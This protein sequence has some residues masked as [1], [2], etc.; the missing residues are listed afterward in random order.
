[1]QQGF[2]KFQLFFQYYLE[3]HDFI[4]QVKESPLSRLQK[5]AIKDYNKIYK[6]K[7]RPIKYI[8]IFFGF[9]PNFKSINFLNFLNIFIDLLVN[10]YVD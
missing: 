7:L 6:E 10:L 5:S 8:L 1:M 4:T 9:G 2:S 3:E